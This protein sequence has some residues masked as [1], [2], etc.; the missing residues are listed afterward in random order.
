MRAAV[1]RA[2]QY[3]AAS[4]RENS[5]QIF[6]KTDI[7]GSQSELLLAADHYIQFFKLIP[8]YILGEQKF[9]PSVD[10]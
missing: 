5:T 8:T 6:I 4:F 3:T 2:P 7:L 10:F 1:Q 9:S